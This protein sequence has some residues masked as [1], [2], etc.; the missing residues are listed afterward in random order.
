[1]LTV[2]VQFL[3]MRILFPFTQVLPSQQMFLRHLT[4]FKLKLKPKPKPE[5][6][7]ELRLA[8]VTTPR[9][10]VLNASLGFWCGNLIPTH[11]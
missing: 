9:I 4:A 2:C 11:N 3:N 5:P 1:M 7:A 6:S 10:C 8:Q